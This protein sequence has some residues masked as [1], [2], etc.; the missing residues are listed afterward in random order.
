MRSINCKRTPENPWQSACTL[1]II[2]IFDK[3]LSI[4]SPTPTACVISKFV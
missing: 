2:I 4:F 3:R 1:Q